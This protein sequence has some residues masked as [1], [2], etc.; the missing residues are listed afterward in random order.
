MRDTLQSTYRHVLV[1]EYQD[2]NRASG[3]FLKEV[4]GAGAGLWVVGDTRQAIYRFRGAAPTNMQRFAEDFPGAKIKSLRYNYRF[5]PAIVDVFAGL[6][7]NMRASRGGPSFSRWEPKRSDSGGRVLMEVAA[8]LTAEAGGI[9]K[10][11]ERQRDS[12]LSISSDVAA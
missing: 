3:L 11:I 12:G 2:V 10:E 1:D 8:D 9:A 6:A 5:Q 4:A 7:P